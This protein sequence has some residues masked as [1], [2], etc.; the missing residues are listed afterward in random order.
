MISGG[1]PFPVVIRPSL[2]ALWVLCRVLLFV[3]PASVGFSNPSYHSMGWFLG[4]L[5]VCCGAAAL[6]I[7]R[8]RP[9][10]VAL[11]TPPLRC[12]DPP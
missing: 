3:G 9:S 5:G 6:F 10:A 8:H 1:D 2:V 7:D 11:A 4:A 12:P